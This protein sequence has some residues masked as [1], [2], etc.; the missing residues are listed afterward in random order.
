V[1]SLARQYLS[2]FSAGQRLSAAVADVNDVQ[3]RA[4]FAFFGEGEKHEVS[5][6][7]SGLAI[8]RPPHLLAE[9]ARLPFSHGDVPRQGR[10]L[11]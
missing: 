1:S 4:I 8:N 11:G 7:C 6:R 5:G 9:K 2:R 3:G 10:Q